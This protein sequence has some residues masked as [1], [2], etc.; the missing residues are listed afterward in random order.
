MTSNINFK[1]PHR[2]IVTHCYCALFF[3]LV[4]SGYHT[5]L[6]LLGITA[7]LEL[8]GITAVLELF[9]TNVRCGNLMI[10]Q[11]QIFSPSSTNK[12]PSRIS[13]FQLPSIALSHPNLFYSIRTTP[14]YLRPLLHSLRA[15]TH[16]QSNP[17]PVMFTI[18]EILTAVSMKTSL[19]W[20][21]VPFKLIKKSALFQRTL[22]P[23]SSRSKESV[24]VPWRWRQPSPFWNFG[25]YQSTCSPRSVESMTWL[26]WNKV[27]RPE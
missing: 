5:V 20:N 13:A 21:S 14:T 7:V 25:I 10:Y 12:S 23:S 18:V 16:H 8:L 9:N 17:Q 22:L 2:L 19:L 24:L 27:R 3:V 4:L 15:N 1:I 6:P 11:W 26:V